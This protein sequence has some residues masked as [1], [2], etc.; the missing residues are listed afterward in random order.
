MEDRY[1]VIINLGERSVAIENIDR[2]ERQRLLDSVRDGD[3]IFS[4]IDELGDEIFVFINNIKS[5][6]IIRLKSKKLKKVK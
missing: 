2:Y 1:D 4:Y 5:F 3:T 6:E